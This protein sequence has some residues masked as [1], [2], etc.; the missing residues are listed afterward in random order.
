[1]SFVRKY[2]L[3]AALGLSAVTGASADTLFSNGAAGVDSN[4][5]AGD[6]QCLGSWEIVTPIVLGS[7]SLLT[8]LNFTLSNVN[9]AF[10]ST[11]TVLVDIWTAAPTLATWTS[12]SVFS[13]VQSASY[14]SHVVDVA[15][16]GISLG[17]GDYWIGFMITNDLGVSTYRSASTGLSTQWNIDPVTFAPISFRGDFGQAAIRVNGTIVSAVPEPETYAMLMAGLGV[18]GF[19]SR[20]RRKAQPGLA[21]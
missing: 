11:N 5:C 6:N 7:N 17:A 3:V 15:L 1:M 9:S 20:R 19:V 10:S 13:G 16:P 14:A 21:G 12:S 2:A 18:M 8:S 4:R